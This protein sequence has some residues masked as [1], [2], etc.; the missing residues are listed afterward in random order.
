[1]KRIGERIRQLQTR[2]QDTAGDQHVFPWC[3]MG[4]SFTV[5]RVELLREVVRSLAHDHI[6]V[7]VAPDGFGKTAFLLQCSDEVMGDP[8]RGSAFIMD[9]Y[10][11]SCAQVIEQLEECM[12]TC[13]PLTHPLVALDNVPTWTDERIATFVESLSELIDSGFDVILSCKP[14]Q[15][16]LLY[17]LRDIPKIN[18]QALKVRPKEYSTWLRTFSIAHT[19]DVYQLTQGVP[20]LIASLAADHDVAHGETSFLDTCID[21]LYQTML[22]ELALDGAHLLQLMQLIL[23]MG[24]G[25][26]DELSYGGFEVSPENWIRLTHDYPV[27]GY[28]AIE[29]TFECLGYASGAL[30]V[31]RR[32]IAHEEPA[33]VMRAVRTLMHC[34]RIDDAVKLTRGYLELCDQV[35][36]VVQYALSF[37]LAGY[38]EMVITTLTQADRQGITVAQP[39]R[40]SLALYAAS[41]TQGEYKMARNMAAALRMSAG[42]VV[43]DIDITEWD[44]VQALAD[45]WDTCS[46]IEL[47]RVTF[48]S[49]LRRPLQSAV[50]LRQFARH[51]RVVLGKGELDETLHMD[52]KITSNKSARARLRQAASCA[53][54]DIPTILLACADVVDKL[55]AGE[56]SLLDGL[57]ETLT[58]LIHELQMRG[59]VPILCMV[60]TTVATYRM[61]TG[62]PVEDDHVFADAE[63]MAIRISNQRL[64][65]FCLMLEGWHNLLRGQAVSAQFRGAQI[66]RLAGEQSSLIASWALLLE[67]A[68]HLRSTSRLGVCEEAETLDLTPGVRSSAEAWAVALGLSAA[69]LDGELAAWYSLRKGELM[70]PTMRMPVRLALQTMG[71]RA[72][73]MCRLIP[74]HVLGYYTFDNVSASPMIDEPKKQLPVISLQ[75][76]QIAIKLFGGFRAERAGQ[77]LTDVL[78]RRRKISFLAAR[79]V[80]AMGSYVGRKM[81]M[82]EMW[83]HA[84]YQHARNSLYSALTVLR[85]AMGQ[86]RRG[87]PQYILV[88]G[89]GVA[90]N[91]DYVLSD[92]MMFERFARDVLLRHTGVSNADLVERC[93]KLE[94]IY[95][96][97]LYAPHQGGPSFFKR[98]R[99][100]CQTKFTDCMLR[101]I[102]AAVEEEDVASASWLTDAAL[103][104]A[105]HRE[106]VIRQAMQVFDMAGRHR[107]V[108]ELYHHHA[109]L[110]EQNTGGAPEPQ[111]TALFEQLM[112]YSR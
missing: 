44:C 59:L 22:D 73:S 6:A 66:L 36:L 18:A 43:D 69:R 45:I 35:E 110:V 28:N 80:L 61:F 100:T 56:E 11:A 60:R 77:T 1:M 71:D 52:H 38:A 89:E 107:E 88:Q 92:V 94:Q 68:A 86:N 20:A 82:D 31:I 85:R 76:N 50:A 58:K 64:Q 106:D 41:L 46:G 93:L 25:S 105:S 111:T 102:K 37:V 90:I 48:A 19:V 39:T 27:F 78:W 42:S 95:T 109:A 112:G 34:R 81:L 4:A 47:P 3:P 101:G 29:H 54:V 98:M 24:A 75:E 10:G 2:Q 83:P 103:H 108:S 17:R 30:N 23:L 7:V 5:N 33:L 67:R 87:G 12:Q 79:L 55:V 65:L 8:G 62:E 40:A 63:T 72:E 70:D 32:R 15:R 53:V 97:P 13:N 9:A 51:I 84:E 96:G 74:S 99:A 57:V 14:S 21:T 91:T 26:A 104:Q 16:E 49:R